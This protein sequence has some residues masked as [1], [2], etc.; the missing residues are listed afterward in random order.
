MRRLLLGTILALAAQPAAADLGGCASVETPA[1][2][3]RPHVRMPAGVV[4]HLGP[5]EVADLVRGERRKLVIT[6]VELLPST[7]PHGETLPQRWVVHL[8]APFTPIVRGAHGSCSASH[9][10]V[11]VHDESREIAWRRGL[12]EKCRMQPYA[13]SISR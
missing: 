4:P 9:Q 13:W 11:V 2:V 10:M 5:F 6:C 12:D 8:E 7:R 3:G 1:S